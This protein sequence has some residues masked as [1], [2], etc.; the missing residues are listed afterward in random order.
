M[1][2]PYL[3]LPSRAMSDII[4]LFTTERHGLQ[5]AIC[6]EDELLAEK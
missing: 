6:E 4:Y 5:T 1:I 3:V 2:G